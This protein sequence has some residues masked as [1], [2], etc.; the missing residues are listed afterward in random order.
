MFLSNLDHEIKVKTHKIITG[1]A[2]IILIFEKESLAKYPS[3]FSA[4]NKAA[5]IINKYIANIKIFIKKQIFKI[6]F[7]IIY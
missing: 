5:S 6:I 1:K 4:L 7:F 3:N 2:N